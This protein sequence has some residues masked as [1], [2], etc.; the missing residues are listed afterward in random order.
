[1]VR[2]QSSGRPAAQ[3]VS[4]GTSVEVLHRS[5]KPAKMRGPRRP[6]QRASLRAGTTAQGT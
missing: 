6:G 1:M 5:A 4:A 2:A 3:E